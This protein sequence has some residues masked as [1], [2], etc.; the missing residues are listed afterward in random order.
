MF[1]TEKSREKSAISAIFRIFFCFHVCWANW[2]TQTILRAWSDLKEE[3]R[4]MC[5]LGFVVERKETRWSKI[6]NFFTSK[7]APPP[8]PGGLGVLPQRF[9]K[10][11]NC[12]FA[13]L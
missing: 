5:A 8:P 11:M 9:F 10:I 3:V 12:I 4:A 13:D 1:F 2:R 7:R 6:M